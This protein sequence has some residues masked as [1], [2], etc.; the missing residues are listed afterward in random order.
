MCS[1]ACANLQADPRNC[2]ACGH[3]CPAGFSCCSGVCASLFADTNN[4]GACGKKCP[5]GDTCRTGV[6]LKPGMLPP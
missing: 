3:V 6:C 2:G 1:G 5:V 4:C